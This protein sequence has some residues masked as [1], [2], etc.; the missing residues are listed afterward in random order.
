VTHRKRNEEPIRI[1]KVEKSVMMDNIESQEFGCCTCVSYTCA[2]LS[3]DCQFIIVG[4]SDCSISVW[5]VEKGTLVK[6][7]RNH[8]G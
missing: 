2:T 8:N 1:S 5:N 3:Q 6:E 7:Y 4:A